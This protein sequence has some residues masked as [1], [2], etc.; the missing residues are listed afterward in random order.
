LHYGHLFA[1]KSD[2]KKPPTPPTPDVEDRRR[3]PRKTVAST[4]FIWSPTT[5]DPS[6]RISVSTVNVSSKGVA[7][8]SPSA[9][10]VHAYYMIEIENAETR[11]TREIRTNRCQKV[12]DCKYRVAAN[13]S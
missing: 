6:K 7:F 2:M 13:F 8:D 5:K 1:D 10:A 9:I 12:T 3:S 4:A 11:M